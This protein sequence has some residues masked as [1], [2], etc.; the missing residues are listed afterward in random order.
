MID[1]TGWADSMGGNRRERDEGLKTPKAQEQ[2]RKTQKCLPAS[3]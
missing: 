1:A 3:Q 2:M